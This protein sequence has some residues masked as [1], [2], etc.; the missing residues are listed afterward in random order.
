[1]I[2]YVIIKATQSLAHHISSNSFK[3]SSIFPQKVTDSLYSKISYWNH[4]KKNKY[5][6]KSPF[7]R[8]S[9]AAARQYL[10]FEFNTFWT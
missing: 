5:R 3:V 8:V 4:T 10:P 2:Q 1:M 7:H 6:Y 9:F